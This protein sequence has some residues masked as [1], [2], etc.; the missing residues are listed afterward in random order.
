M[1]EGKS[2]SEHGMSGWWFFAEMREGKELG[3]WRGIS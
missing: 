2:K 3:G 1:D